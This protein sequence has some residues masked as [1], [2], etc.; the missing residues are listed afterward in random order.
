MESNL[1]AFLDKMLRGQIKSTI[2][3]IKLRSLRSGLPSPNE[4]NL[5]SLPE[6]FFSA[7]LKLNEFLG[8]CKSQLN[9]IFNYIKLSPSN[10]YQHFSK[11]VTKRMPATNIL[12]GLLLETSGTVVINWMNE[13]NATIYERLLFYDKMRE[14]SVLL[15]K[16]EGTVALLV[17]DLPNDFK[18]SRHEKPTKNTIKAAKT[19]RT[20]VAAF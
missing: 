5:I 2:T 20:P 13:G 17:N 1:I 15:K 7:S 6:D 8:L 10:K 9:Q 19:D 14:L 18:L 3:V 11:V 12:A 4:L 16:E